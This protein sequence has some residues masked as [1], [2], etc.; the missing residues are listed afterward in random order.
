MFIRDNSLLI[1]SILGSRSGYI[2]L[3]PEHCQVSTCDNST[4]NSFI[5]GFLELSYFF[6]PHPSAFSPQA[7][8]LRPQASGFMPHDYDYDYDDDYDYDYDHD[9]DYDYDYDYVDDLVDD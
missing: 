6:I 2:S 7:P 8:G 9:Y 1:S 3:D 4:A 5:F